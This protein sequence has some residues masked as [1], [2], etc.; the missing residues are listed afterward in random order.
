[1][2]SSNNGIVTTTQ[3]PNE[4]KKLQIKEEEKESIEFVLGDFDNY[5]KVTEL[6][7]FK[8]MT[9][10]ALV[11]ESIKSISS[12]VENLP[13]PAQLKYLCLNENHLTNLDG[14]EKLT[15]LEERRTSS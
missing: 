4:C 8:N 6:A 11:Y 2:H 7:T 15:N 5:H 9:S 12:I 10:L 3:I 13:N 1:M 14:V